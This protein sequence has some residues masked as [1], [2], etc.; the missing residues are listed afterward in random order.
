MTV[1]RL[2]MRPDGTFKIV[3]FTDLHWNNGEEADMRTRALMERVVA[4]ERPDLIVF[5]GDVIE[6][7]RCRD[8]ERSFKDAVSV[9]ADSGVPWAA[10][11]GNHDS[12]GNVTR[13]Q[14]MRA[15]LSLPGAVA[16]FGPP[17]LEGVGNFALPV[18]DSAG[19]R[20]AAALYCFD[21]GSYSDLAEAPGYGW[22]GE[23]QLAWFRREAAALRTAGGGVP[24]PSLAFMHIPLPE[25]REVWNSRYCYGRRHE[26]VNC[27]P[28]NSGLF[29]AMMES[30]A[31][32]GV[33]CGHDHIN[34]YVGELY[35][36]RLCY[37]RATGYA[38][39]GRWLYSRG[40]RVIRLRQG[41]PF[42]TWLR[43]ATGRVITQPRKHRPTCF[44]RA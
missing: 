36:I 37:G 35:G 25:Y 1:E 11:F 30:G 12:E 29:A 33:F 42:D 20:L 13:E 38:T 3:Q 17:E 10:L 41:K 28:I 4:A 39:Y 44:S 27:A 8:P 23:R 26:K 2:R 5:T 18:W 24:V 6:S 40:A 19:V 32:R 16:E 34:D 14:L 21:S 9:A 31:V 43:L 22:I 15:Q 7:R